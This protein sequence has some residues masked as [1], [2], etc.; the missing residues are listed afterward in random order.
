MGDPSFHPALPW[1]IEFSSDEFKTEKWRNF[2]KTKFRMNKGDEQLDLTFSGPRAH[3]IIDILTDVTYFV[4][5]A[6]RTPIPVFSFFFF[7]FSFFS[8][9]LFFSLFFQSFL[10][11]DSLILSLLLSF[12]FSFLLF[13]SQDFSSSLLSSDLS[14]PFLSFLFFLDSRTKLLHKG[15]TENHEKKEE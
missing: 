8:F 14:F 13:L 7:L 10:S 9:L 12:L 5:K 11:Q 1:V 2:Q 15:V 6:R 4:Y 3:H